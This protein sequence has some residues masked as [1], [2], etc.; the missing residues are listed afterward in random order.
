MT[1][2]EL[3]ED[4][5]K[6]LESPAYFYNNYCVVMDKTTGKVFKPKTVTDEQIEL[7][8]QWHEAQRKLRNPYSLG[9]ALPD[10]FKELI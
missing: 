7:A 2:E 9:E 4:Y 3:R 10:N 5:M 8:R 6:C 1:E